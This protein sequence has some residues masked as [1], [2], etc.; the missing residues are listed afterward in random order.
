MYETADSVENMWKVWLPFR[1][2]VK[3]MQEPGFIIMGREVV[4]FHGGDYH[5]QDDTAGHQGSSVKYLCLLAYVTLDHLR[6]HDGKTHTPE[7]C[8][9]PND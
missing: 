1:E 2:Q 4:I 7:T 6:E 5:Y 3:E 9:I 8:I